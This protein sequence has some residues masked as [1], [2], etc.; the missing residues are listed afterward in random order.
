MKKL[1]IALGCIAVALVASGTAACTVKIEIDK[2]PDSYTVTFQNPW[3]GVS[4]STVKNGELVVR[5]EDPERPGYVFDGWYLNGVE[6]TFGEAVTGDITLVAKYTSVLGGEGTASDPFTIDNADELALVQKY[7][8]DGVSGFASAHYVQTANIDCSTSLVN[9]VAEFSGTYDGG[10]YE[11]TVG[12]PLFEK[13]SGVVKD[14]TING[15]VSAKDRGGLLAAT[16]D[17]ATVTRVNAI[18][19]VISIDSYTNEYT[20]VVGG[21]VGEQ[22]GGRIEYCTAKVSAMA[23]IAGGIVGKSG[24]TVINGISESSVVAEDYAGGVVGVLDENGLIQNVGASKKATGEFVSANNGVAGGI[25]GKKHVNSAV[26]RAF[27][28]GGSITGKRAGIAAGLVDSDTP[29]HSEIAGCAA[30]A[31]VEVNGTVEKSN[32]AGVAIAESLKDFALPAAVWNTSGEIPALKENA[33]ALPATVVMTVNGTATT[34]E[35]GY[36]ADRELF[37]EN[38]EHYSSLIETD[39][40]VDLKTVLRLH[41]SYAGSEFVAGN[42]GYIFAA[43]GLKYK[44]GGAELAGLDYVITY[45]HTDSLFYI[46]NFEYPDRGYDVDYDAPVS[47]YTD[48]KDYYAFTVAKQYVGPKMY[49]AFMESFVLGEDGWEPY[50]SLSPKSDYSG[51]AYKYSGQIIGGTV[52][53]MIIVDDEYKTSGG[54]GYYNTRYV[55][56]VYDED[57]EYTESREVIGRGGTAMYLGDSENNPYTAVFTYEVAYDGTVN[58]YYRDAQGKL[59]SS[60]GIELEDASGDFL[61]GTWFDGADK[62]TFDTENHSVA[63]TGESGTTSADYTVES[64][65]IKFAYGNKNYELKFVPGALGSYM[66][67]NTAGGNSLVLA[68]YVTA[69]LDGTWVTEDGKTITVT[70]DPAALITVDGVTA[71]EVC[72]NVY[73]G[74]QAL[75]FT[76]GDK[77]YSLVTYSDKNVALLVCGDIAVYAFDKEMLLKDYAGAF[78]TV[79]NSTLTEMEIDEDFNITYGSESA[80]K[81]LPKKTSSGLTVDYVMTATINNLAYTLKRVNDVV[82][83]SFND[84]ERVFTD[85]E[86]FGRFAVTYTNGAEIIEV[87]ENGRYFYRYARGSESKGENYGLTA[88]YRE[89]RYEYGLEHRGF[90]LYYT[91]GE[92]TMFLYA[93]TDTTNLRLFRPWVNSVGNDTATLVTNFVPESELEP[94]YGSYT[95]MYNNAVDSLTF[96]ED[97]TLKRTYVDADGTAHENELITWYPVMNY[98][99]NTKESSVIV[100][101][102]EITEGVGFTTRIDFTVVG[103]V[104][105]LNNEYVSTDSAAQ[106][107]VEYADLLYVNKDSSATITVS[108]S[109]LVRKTIVNANGKY[110]ETRATF[111]FDTVTIE[112]ENSIIIEMS[113]SDGKAIAVLNKI[114]NGY[115]VTITDLNGTSTVYYGEQPLD[116]NSLV[117][118]YVNNGVSY[119]FT[120]VDDGWMGISIRLTISTARR[121]YSYSTSNGIALM[122]DGSRALLMTDYSNYSDPTKYVWKKGDSLY[123]SNSLDASEAVIAEDAAIGNMPSI[124]ELKV[125]LGGN[126]Y[127]ASDG[128]KVSF[129]Y[130]SGSGSYLEIIDGDKGSAYLDDSGHKKEKGLYTLVFGLEDMSADFVCYVKVYLNDMGT[131]T[132]LMIGETEETATKEYL[133]NIVYPTVNELLDILKDNSYKT[134]DDLVVSFSKA[135]STYSINIDGTLYDYV[136]DSGSLIDG[137][138]TLKFK[139]IIGSSQKEVTIT[140]GANGVEKV[141]VDGKDYL[142]IQPP[143]ID[144]LQENLNGAVFSD[145]KGHWLSFELTTGVFGSFNV[146]IYDGENRT[147]F[148]M[149]KS[150]NQDGNAYVLTFDYLTPTMRIEFDGLGQVNTI[151]LDGISYTALPTAEELLVDLDEAVYENS[152]KDEMSFSVYPG[153]FGGPT[154]Y[155]V[156]IEGI[157][158]NLIASSYS[159]MVCTMEFESDENGNKVTLVVTVGY[160][161]KITKISYN[162]SDYTLKAAE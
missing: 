72:D 58:F 40:D 122:S 147:S 81:L 89:E 62:F 143:T 13:L 21:I 17:N 76:L 90:V 18:G 104:W 123:I 91:V 15:I 118:E 131:I 134:S 124:D 96:G 65:R 149:Y 151:I 86:T 145:G 102:H 99:S 110:S 121:P 157:E 156:T 42:D 130:V 128:T 26:Y 3:G 137:V 85:S 29:V 69:A 152:N 136:K 48:G 84:D 8:A 153:L 80:V 139:P 92:Q 116:Y 73:N 114:N 155:S 133:P 39:T 154:T 162:G 22:K 83:V 44:K 54:V 38:D 75:A 78:T 119:N 20:G 146:E 103:L 61:A 79:H 10:G 5:P 144:E 24:G 63:I 141:T 56:R 16:A 55:R 4:E 148:G 23:K 109:R 45:S 6:Y 95:R 14:L 135:L 140:Y 159:G 27:V 71:T 25:V 117:G 57:G 120:V 74:M 2:K 32:Y 67:V 107:I 53:Y 100:Y 19:S 126:E 97:G 66:L 11:L 64:G 1:K 50:K 129:G 127:T 30:L 115:T 158:Y 33:D 41:T 46:P 34:V 142:P 43:S 49:M 59:I 98:N 94:I 68:T 101:T 60:E 132:K 37:T 150:Y 161:N 52:T 111:D 160:D 47:V 31:S 108:T 82:T 138:Y 35:Y 105:G 28:Y 113:N 87:A 9:S 51:G 93:D 77:E 70:T 36:K 125:M 7:I 106:S 12:K 88:G 112:S